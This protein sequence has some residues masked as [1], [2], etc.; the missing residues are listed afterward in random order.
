MQSIQLSNGL[1]ITLLLL[2]LLPFVITILFGGRLSYLSDEERKN[3]IFARRARVSYSKWLIYNGANIPF[4]KVY[5][6][7]DYL[8]IVCFGVNRIYYNNITSIDWGRGRTIKIKENSGLNVG[9]SLYISIDYKKFKLTK[10]N[11]VSQLDS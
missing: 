11:G 4:W 3:L 7:K 2:F 5:F 8:A 6:F 9:I 10:I 1:A